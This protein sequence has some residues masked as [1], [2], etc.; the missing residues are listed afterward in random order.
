MMTGNKEQQLATFHDVTH[1]IYDEVGSWQTRLDV[2]DP[3]SLS[4]K[5]MSLKAGRLTVAR[6]PAPAASAQAIELEAIENVIAENRTF[7]ARG[8][9]V[10]YSQAKD[11]LILEG[12]G[13]APAELSF[14]EYVGAAPRT[15][16]ASRIHFRPETQEVKIDDGRSLT[17]GGV[18][19]P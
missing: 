7:T 9:R 5:G 6:A 12:D 11:W 8:N 14:Q 1:C 15:L 19:L 18:P 2:H 13:F 10:T 3:D 17:M 4:K 16:S